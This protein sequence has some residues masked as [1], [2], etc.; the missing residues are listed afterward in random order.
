[1]TFEMLSFGK[2][3]KKKIEKTSFK[4]EYSDSY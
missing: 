4:F 3:K 2:I 1:M